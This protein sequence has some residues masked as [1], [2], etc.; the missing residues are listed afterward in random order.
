VHSIADFALTSDSAV[1]IQ[2]E[3]HSPIVIHLASLNGF[4]DNETITC[5]NLPAYTTCTFTNGTIPLSANQSI[6][7]QVVINT[8]S[9][10]GYQKPS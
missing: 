6:D 7:S 9:V 8:D 4:E 10:L 3:Y 5:E 2:T 1:T